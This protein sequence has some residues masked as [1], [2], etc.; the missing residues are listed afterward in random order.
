[1]NIQ[2]N[3]KPQTTTAST[4]AQLLTEAGFGSKAIATAVNGS[5]VPLALR[6]TY[7]LG[8]G[9]QIEILAPMQGG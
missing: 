4:L 7:E 5:F 1:M 6:D 3:G 8:N 2:L 9:D